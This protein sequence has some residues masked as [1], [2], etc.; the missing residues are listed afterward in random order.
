MAYD[1][2]VNYSVVS[3][4]KNRIINGK[5]DKI[6]EPNFEEIVLGIYSN[7][8]KFALDLVIN[9]QFYRAN[10]TTHTKQNPSQAPNF[11]MTLRKYLLGT[12]I[13]NIYTNNL[14]RIIFIELEGYNKSKDESKKTLV[15]ELM[16][17]HSNII[18]IDK[19][20]MIIDSLKHFSKNSGSYRNIFA[21]EKYTLPK[22]D[23]IDFFEV[24][25]KDEFYRIIENNSIKLN[26]KSLIDIIS[27]TFTGFS[28]SS[29]SA[30]EMSNNLSDSLEKENIYKLFNYITQIVNNSEKNICKKFDNKND[31]FLINSKKENPLEINWFLDDYY[32]SKEVD[33]TFLNYRNGLL[34]LI[35][36]K[37]HKL[38]TKLDLVNE[39]IN[40]CKDINKY[41]LYGELITSNLY[42]IDNHNL[43]SITLDNYYDNNNSITIQLD[44]SIT[45]SSNA[46]KFFK[47]YQKLKNAKAIVEEQKM[48]IVSDIDYLE[49]IVYEIESANNISDVDEIY[50]EISELNM[51]LTNKKTVKKK[52][53]QNKLKKINNIGEP[54]KFNIN[55]FCVLVGKNNKQ[56]DY[57]TTKIANKEDIW[58]HVKD[59]QGSHVIILTDNR[60]PSQETINTCAGL[61]KKYSKASQSSNITVDYTSIKNVKK[62]SGSK[63]GMVIYTNNKSVTVK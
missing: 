38:N 56:N 5:I 31:Y 44:K 4:L 46:K 22:S 8:E 40:E 33:N 51:N 36:N 27:N 18:L 15:V 42:R 14:E 62:P 34:K 58:L 10:L 16:G 12:H 59:F 57:L 43:E 35:L 54:L 48:K 24:K 37:L 7:K 39:K 25:D 19:E 26:S 49:S 29:I 60:I 23:K 9:P 17:K 20:N 32:T 55:G 28:K 50:S 61:A 11:C 63:P 2:L 53:T 6:F 21:G 47:K 1:G 45:P 52:S 41:K 13:V 30:I 3:E